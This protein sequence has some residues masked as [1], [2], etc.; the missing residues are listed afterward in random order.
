MA[1]LNSLYIKAE[2][3]E[4]L[5]K[6]VKEKEMKGVSIT[7]SISDTPNDYGQNVTG[8][9]EQSKEDREAKKPR[10]FIGNGNTFWTDGKITVVKKD[11]QVN[12]EQTNE[13]PDLPF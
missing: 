1:S 11:K 6:T 8:F 5:A 7:V 12:K 13:E 4:T 10:Y 2:T 3:L 9:V